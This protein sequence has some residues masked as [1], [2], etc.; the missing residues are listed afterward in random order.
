MRG[1]GPLDAAERPI[2]GLVGSV[3]TGDVWP[4]SCLSFG[5]TSTSSMSTFG[6]VKE[7]VEAERLLFG[8]AEW[9][10]G[11]RDVFTESDR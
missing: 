2:F 4:L 11:E 6:F 3:L 10:E 1:G 9:V 5:F 7:D 8:R